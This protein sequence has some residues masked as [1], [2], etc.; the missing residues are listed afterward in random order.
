MRVGLPGQEAR[1]LGF[2][3]EGFITARCKSAPKHPSIQITHIG[4]LK[5]LDIN[6]LHWSI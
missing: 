5:L 6:Y 2:V 3:G 1:G 4:P